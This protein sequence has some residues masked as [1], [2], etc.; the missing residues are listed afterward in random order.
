MQLKSIANVSQQKMF[1]VV[2][3]LKLRYLIKKNENFS[4]IGC[5][6]DLFFLYEQDGSKQWGNVLDSVGKN[7]RDE[8]R[9]RS[10]F[11]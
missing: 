10:F 4:I 5:V 8:A 3:L 1:K 2:A 9:D 7:K 11:I 6:I